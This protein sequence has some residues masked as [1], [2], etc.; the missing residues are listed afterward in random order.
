[1][2]RVIRFVLLSTLAL[3]LAVAVTPA[4][5]AATGTTY[6]WLGQRD[7]V[8][9]SDTHDWQNPLNWG[10]AGVPGNGDSVVAV[11][12]P[13]ATGLHLD[14]I[15]SNLS[16]VDLTIADTGDSVSNSLAQVSLQDGSL[17]VTGHLD[18][19][20]GQLRTP[21]TLAAGATGAITG[22]HD[23]AALLSSAMNVYGTVTLS[24]ASGTE[25]L[26]IENPNTLTIERG[27]RLVSAG[28]NT[29]SAGCCIN[30]SRLVNE[31]T[32]QPNGGTLQV[33][34]V[35]L[36]QN[37]T[38]AFD[39]GTLVT[40]S[41]PLG[42]A[43]GGTYTGVGTWAIEDNSGERD[44]L[45]GVQTL[46]A[47]VTLALRTS[48]PDAG[49]AL[50]GRFTL[51]GSGT[52]L[53]A[54]GTL[55]ASATIGHQITVT[56][57]GG[58]GSGNSARVLQGK[59]Y[60]VSSA[61]TQSTFTNHGRVV[62]AGRARLNTSSGARL[63]NAADGTI[64]AAA[65]TAIVGEGC[66][67]D[68]DSITNAGTFAVGADGAGHPVVLGLELVRQSAG[69]MTIARHA[70]LS[71]T[72]SALAVGGGSLVGDGT[73]RG[74]VTNT[75]GRVSPGG[76]A[77]GTL[78]IAGSYAQSRNGVLVIDETTARRHDALAVTGTAGVAGRVMVTDHGASPSA[79][80][81]VT[82]LTSKRLHLAIACIATT[83]AGTSG[84]HARHWTAHA[85]SNRALQLVSAA[86]RHTHC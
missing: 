46:G 75:G 13:G 49:V 44:T 59:D 20:G 17:T 34:G 86:G 33:S 61:G 56:L 73:V 48:S 19:N 85:I 23:D 70:Q 58:P 81:R 36:E 8:P 6:T 52:F 51:A 28:S 1:M 42:A 54:N 41:A 67:L 79:A 74:N 64:S 11:P 24:G 39:H 47:H 40:D 15:P 60:T 10:P 43:D 18:W 2:T 7:G 76:S 31:G 45:T 82:V 71:I 69:T 68:P 53:W 5:S 21:L 16:L 84:P 80:A 65:G 4:A 78:A 9:G 66:C 63:V 77:L 27:G 55:E 38:V 26:S 50:G 32:L 29:V 14:T 3:V 22:G 25:P 83:G 57:S 35:Q 62:L 30:P 12:P 72:Y 37:G